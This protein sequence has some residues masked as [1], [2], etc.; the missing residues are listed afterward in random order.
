MK[1][2]P[3]TEKQVNK[4]LAEL[5]ECYGTL[6]EGKEK[7]ETYHQLQVLRGVKTAND[8]KGHIKAACKRAEK[9]LQGGETDDILFV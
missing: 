8:F 5:S 7:T 9:W 3:K 2:T 4:M 6:P 1:K